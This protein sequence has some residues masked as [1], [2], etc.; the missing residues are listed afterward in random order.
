MGQNQLEA[1]SAVE[2][3]LHFCF[4]GEMKNQGPK[5][6]LVSLILKFRFL[7]KCYRMLITRMKKNL[8]MLSSLFQLKLS[9]TCEQESIFPG[10]F[11]EPQ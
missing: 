9:E 4:G 6:Q 8:Q 5:L 3:H 2:W 11:Q 10:Q 7:F 1:M